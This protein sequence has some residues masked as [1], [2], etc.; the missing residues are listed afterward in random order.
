MTISGILRDMCTFAIE[1]YKSASLYLETFTLYYAVMSGL[2]CFFKDL[3]LG[4]L[5]VKLQALRTVGVPCNA[6][7]VA[8]PSL[9]ALAYI[10][11]IHEEKM[12]LISFFR[13]IEYIVGQ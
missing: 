10:P 8:L 1:K 6:F 12:Y 3:S 2:Y 11:V 9:N 5:L 13:D 7:S 4:C